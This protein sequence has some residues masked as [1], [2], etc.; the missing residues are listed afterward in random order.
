MVE[1]NIA[2][3]GFEKCSRLIRG[4][5]FG[6]LSGLRGQ[7][8]GL[9][10]LDPPY[11]GELLNQALRQI[12]EIDILQTGGIIVCESAREDLIQPLEE[13]YRVKKQYRYGAI[14]ITTFTRGETK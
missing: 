6:A 8:F 9:I 13:P 5:A 2:A 11:G 1:R 14:A 10:L 4:D 3:T 7:K 12:A